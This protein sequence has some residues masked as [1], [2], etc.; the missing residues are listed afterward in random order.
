MLCI[1]FRKDNSEKTPYAFWPRSVKRRITVSAKTITVSAK[2]T[3]PCQLAQYKQADVGKNFLV[4]V[5]VTVHF[6]NVRGP[7]YLMIKSVVEQNGFYK[8][9]ILQ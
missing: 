6:L 8:S 1:V 7:V 9:T 4:L 5:L 2:T 3:H